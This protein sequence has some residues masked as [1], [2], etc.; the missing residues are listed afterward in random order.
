MET[1]SRVQ[2][3]FRIFLWRIFGKMHSSNNQRN[4][5]YHWLGDYSEPSYASLFFHFGQM[6]LYRSSR[7]YFKRWGGGSE[8]FSFGD[9]SAKSSDKR[10]SVRPNCHEDITS[11]PFYFDV[12]RCCARCG[13]P[14]VSYL[15]GDSSAAF[16][17][18]R[19]CIPHFFRQTDD[20]NLILI[21][22]R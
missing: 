8:L 7:K 20:V 6:G 3:G 17:A 15:G 9:H 13:S 5:I 14:C 19:H 11:L 12:D 2:S 22:R 16:S 18:D 4:K 10:R 1:D 21:F